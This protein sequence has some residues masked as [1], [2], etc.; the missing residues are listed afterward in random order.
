M[1]KGNSE[2]K[3]VKVQC[4]GEEKGKDRSTE[5]ARSDCNTAGKGQWAGL[6][7]TVMVSGQEVRR[8]I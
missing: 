5:A 2:E 6:W 8:Q 3:D 4:G 1:E 7:T